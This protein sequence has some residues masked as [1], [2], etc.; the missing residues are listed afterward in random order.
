MDVLAKFQKEINEVANSIISNINTNWDS[1]VLNV[2][3]DAEGID[4]QLDSIIDNELVEGLDIDNEACD[5]IENTF[6]R[7]VK[8]SLQDSNKMWKSAQLKINK[9]YKF[10]LDFND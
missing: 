3:Y 5:V 8:I 6:E 9:D 7:M 1:L 4:Y 2:K 10:S